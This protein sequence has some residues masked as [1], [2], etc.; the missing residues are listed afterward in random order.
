MSKP[1]GWC[2]SEEH[3]SFYCR[4]KKRKPIAVKTGIKG[5]GKIT[6]Q[7]LKTRDTWFNRNPSEFYDCY[8][9]ISPDCWGSM[10]KEHTTLDHIKS[11]TRHPELRF[12]MS[13]LAPACYPCNKLKGSRDLEEL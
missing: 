13:N 5:A 1:C 2:R 8:L 4:L 6:K 9:R 11:R 10:K 3:T 12:T 7:W